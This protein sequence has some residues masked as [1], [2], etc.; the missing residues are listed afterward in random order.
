MRKFSPLNL[1]LWNFSFKYC[2]LY[3][4]FSYFALFDYYDVFSQVLE[5][6]AI[7]IWWF[8]YRWCVK[9]R[10]G[11]CVIFIFIFIWMKKFWPNYISPH[12]VCV[13]HCVNYYLYVAQSILGRGSCNWQSRVNLDVIIE[14]QECFYIRAFTNLITF[15]QLTL[16]VASVIGLSFWGLNFICLAWVLYLN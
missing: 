13:N 10:L 7:C 16:Q 5:N 15:F 11:K 12:Q 4:L 2:L 6:N 8:A 9:T 1:V 14:L 3:F